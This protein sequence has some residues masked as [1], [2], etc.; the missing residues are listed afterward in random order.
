MAY[1]FC[2]S[3]H[4]SLVYFPTLVNLE[5][6]HKRSDIRAIIS[7]NYQMPSHFFSLCL[8]P[9]NS[10]FTQR[11]ELPRCSC[12]L[13]G[14]QAL[15]ENM[16]TLA[17]TVTEKKVWLRCAELWKCPPFMSLACE[18]TPHLPI[19]SKLSIPVLFLIQSYQDSTVTFEPWNF[20]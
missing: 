3:T 17:F 18:L 1:S 19:T 4:I 5:T 9:F 14:G 15:S 8:P 16:N 20:G 11:Q 13:W 6:C 7:G 10:C 2:S 12:E